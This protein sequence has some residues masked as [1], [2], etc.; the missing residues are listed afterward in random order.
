[1][2]TQVLSV[3]VAQLF[4]AA[5]NPRVWSKQQTGVIALVKDHN[6][7]SYFIHFIN[8]DVSLHSYRQI[9]GVSQIL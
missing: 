3:S 1:M 7:R 2:S 6:Q 4:H 9:L 8:L 5:P